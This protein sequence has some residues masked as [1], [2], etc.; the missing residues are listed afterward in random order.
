M[1][2]KIDNSKDFEKLQEA[3]DGYTIQGHIE[4]AIDGIWFLVDSV[5]RDIDGEIFK[6]I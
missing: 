2:I 6:N 3:F 1:K 4:V 5:K